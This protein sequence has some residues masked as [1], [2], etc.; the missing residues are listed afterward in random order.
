M[1]ALMSKH[2]KSDLPGDRG[3]SCKTNSY[4]AAWQSHIYST[5]AHTFLCMFMYCNT[6]EAAYMENTVMESLHEVAFPRLLYLTEQHE[7]VKDVKQYC[8][9]SE[10]KK[11]LGDIK[12]DGPKEN[13]LMCF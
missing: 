5:Y 4:F 10:N 3:E 1:F 9:W 6:F 7:Q 8:M 2:I 11:T 12:C 13:M